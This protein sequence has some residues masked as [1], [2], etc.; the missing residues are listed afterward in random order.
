[1]SRL[2]NRLTKAEFWT[3]GELLRWPRE[4]RWTWRGLWHLAEDSG[5]LA[6]DP[7]EW[8]CSLW[9]SPLDDDISIAQLTTWR[10]EWVAD[11][12]LVPYEAYGKRCLF[13][14]EFH[15]EELPR[16]PQRWSVPLPPWIAYKPVTV[17]RGKSTTTIN[18]YVVSPKKA[19]QGV[20]IPTSTL[21][22]RYRHANI[23]PVPSRPV[24]TGK[25]KGQDRPPAPTGGQPACAL[26]TREITASEQADEAVAA[27][28]DFGWAHRACVESAKKG[29]TL[30][31][32]PL[33]RVVTEPVELGGRLRR[34]GRPS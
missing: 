19:P 6:D 7:F 27:P 22:S 30:P 11:G 9:S 13:I 18:K 15:A 33:P 12:Y 24:Q 25:G 34:P 20:H 28:F 14:R 16:N 17:A 32:G 5:C 26:C 21:P 2:R 29:G 8:K 31:Q 23:T 3:D 4:K 1:M 10:D